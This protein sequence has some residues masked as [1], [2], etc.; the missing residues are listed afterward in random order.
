MGGF[1][2]TEPRRPRAPS[3]AAVSQVAE[4]GLRCMETTGVGRNQIKVLF[5][6]GGP[7]ALALPQERHGT[8]SHSSSRS[9]E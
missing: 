8:L 5:R 3:S 7:K 4:A 1:G 9:P 6:G 2:G